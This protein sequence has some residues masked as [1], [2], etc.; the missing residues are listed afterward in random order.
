M[1]DMENLNG[2]MQMCMTTTVNRDIV[3][4]MSC[5]MEAARQYA[6]LNRRMHGVV[7]ARLNGRELRNCMTRRMNRKT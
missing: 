3:N 4:A 2:R 5:L 6:V 1:E 7:A